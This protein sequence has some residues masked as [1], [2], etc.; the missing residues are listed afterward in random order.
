MKLYLLRHGDAERLSAHGDRGRELTEEG[1][2]QA[3]IAGR[4]L[5]DIHPGV[6]LISTFIRAKQTLDIIH[7]EC[8]WNNMREF[9][10]LDVAPSGS[11]DDLMLE[12]RAYKEDSL[13]VVGHNP[14]LS[15][16]VYYL[17]DTEVSMGNC[18]FAQIDLDTNKLQKFLKVEEM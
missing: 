10:S 13:L 16:L 7:D 18:S 17:T 1:R 6:V 12:I 11:I 15:E 9:V 3:K 2:N 8:S 14:Q 4:Y 5:K